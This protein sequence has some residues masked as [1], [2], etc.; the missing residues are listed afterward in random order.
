MKSN[1]QNKYLKYKIKYLELKNNL[2]GGD[3]NKLCIH[4]FEGG[5]NIKS[6]NKICK[7][8]QKKYYEY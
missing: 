8:C 3:I 4:E 7:H 1:Y 6:K 2:E 5:G